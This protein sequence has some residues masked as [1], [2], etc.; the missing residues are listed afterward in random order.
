MRACAV[1]ERGARSVACGCSASP[2]CQRRNTPSG[3]YFPEL[4]ADPTRVRLACQLRPRSDVAV[5][6]LVPRDA[7]TAFLHR[8]QLRVIAEERFLALMFVDMRGSTELAAARLPYDHVFIL[9]RFVAAVSAA[10]LAAGGMPNQFLGDGVLALF[11]LRTDDT[12]AC[13]QAI[14]A[15]GAVAENIDALNEVLAPELAAPIRF[16]IGLHCGRTVLGE[17][18]FRDHVTFT[19]LG[20]AP[21]VASRLEGL[22]KE[23]NCEAVVSEDVLQRVDYRFDALPPYEAQLRGRAETVPTRLFRSIRPDLWRLRAQGVDQLPAQ[24]LG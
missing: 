8:R 18:G 13:R 16:G 19:A 23:L 2:F 4:G 5:L 3:S 1:G 14:E 11:G 20:D 7:Q 15:L 17:I 12:T 9:G 21:N 6:P 22:C 24:R 10:V